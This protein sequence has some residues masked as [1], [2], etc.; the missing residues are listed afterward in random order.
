[1]KNALLIT[2]ACAASISATAQMSHWVYAPAYDSIR[3]SDD[4]RYIV[5]D[6]AGT[7]QLSSIDGKVLYSTPDV[8]SPFKEGLSVIV[9]R[10]TKE[11]TGFIDTEGKFTA[12][13]G[14]EVAYGD[15]YFSDG[16]LLFI[17][18]GN[19][20]Y[21]GTD[22]A[23]VKI[24]VVQ[25]AYPYHNGYAPQLGYVQ[26][27]LKIKKI[28]CFFYTNDIGGQILMSLDDK[29]VEDKDMTFTSGIGDDGKGVVIIK[30]KLYWFDSASNDLSPMYG[31]EGEDAEVQMTIDKDLIGYFSH[32]PE[33]PVQ[34]MAN[35]GK[36]KTATLSFDD[37]LQPV[38][39]VFGD[40]TIDFAKEA[41]EKAAVPSN[42]TKEGSAAPY[43]LAYKGIKISNQQFQDVA[44]TFDDCAVVKTDDK[45]GIIGIIATPDIDITVNNGREVPFRHNTIDTKLVVKLPAEFPSADLTVATDSASEMTI[46]QISRVDKNTDYGNFVI[47]D[48][49]LRMPADLPT[50]V[51]DIAYPIILSYDGT[52]LP[53]DT[54]NVKAWYVN[55]YTV[56]P[57]EAGFSTDKGVL[58]F[59]FD[60]DKHMI[61]SEID[62]PF[63]VEVALGQAIL[64]PTK[65]SET[66]YKVSAPGLTPG[67]Y[68]VNISVKEK[69]CPTISFPFELT[70]K[71]SEDGE[72]PVAQLK[73]ADPIP[74]QVTMPQDQ[75]MQMAQMPYALA[76]QQPYEAPV[77]QQYAAP[78]QQQYAAPAQQQYAAPA[79]Q[80]YAAPA[81]QQYAAP[82]QQQYAA[83]AQQQYAAPA[84][85]QYAAPAQQQYAAPAQQQ[86]AAPA[87]QQY[88][89][90]AQQQYAAPAQQQYTTPAQY[91][92]VQQPT[93]Q[94]VPAQQYT[95]PAQQQ[96]IAP[97][98]QVQY[99]SV[100]VR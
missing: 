25:R 96:Y 81:Q 15:P 68:P 80:Q 85:Q 3:I 72:A 54:V 91:T 36:D 73:M 76:T 100:P 23:K 59:A 26:A 84:Q 86:Y 65:V 10:G 41:P 14:G 97:A 28:P 53:A 95:Q 49:T 11:I 88:A 87:Q 1:M 20:G 2:L 67:V 8:I 93:Q 21:Y 32:L 19:Y 48:C 18:D 79:Q 16:M 57:V 78:A 69:D 24:P 71:I 5:T 74:V 70:Y 33:G 4:Y 50:T 63:E 31:G 92:P 42:L 9:K 60:V 17:K 94:Y 12:L 40:T 27:L 52:D 98:Q 7:S 47:M 83:P 64:P 90:P 58:S 39:F 29:K 35:Y 22:G 75:T 56:D 37:A 61:G 82:A 51:T 13:D 89:A 45:W 66:R 30:N 55:Y 44:A 46:D 62:Y 77:A 38:K 43:T 34:F 99:V 6:S